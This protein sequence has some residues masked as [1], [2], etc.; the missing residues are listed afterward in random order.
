MATLDL[1]GL[2]TY[3]IK[4][5]NY[6]SKLYT[7]QPLITAYDTRMKLHIPVVLGAG[8]VHAMIAINYVEQLKT[9]SV[10][11]TLSIA[12]TIGPSCLSSIERCP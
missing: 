11:W 10:Q 2:H 7:Y 6:I 9:H 5:A 3:K 8:T 12:D 4:Y 1:C